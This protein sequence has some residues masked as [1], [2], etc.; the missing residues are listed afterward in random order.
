MD[1]EIRPDPTPRE[2]E[3]IVVA[4]ERLLARNSMPA[5]YTSRWRE[6]GLRENIGDDADAPGAQQ[7][8]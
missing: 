7:P 4:L 3:A 6:A 1:Y 8:S 2:R 5:P